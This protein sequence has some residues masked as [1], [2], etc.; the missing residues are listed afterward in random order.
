M[1]AVEQL[2]P[3]IGV[4]PACKALGVVRATWYRRQQSGDSCRKLRPTPERAL[5]PE[6][7]Q[8]VL[9]TLHSPRFAD[10]SPAEVYATL[11]D[12]GTY[13]CSVS[14]PESAYRPCR[15]RFVDDFEVRCL[16]AG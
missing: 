1:E 2:L 10:Q 6:E 3:S 15:P 9:D 11:L 12:E 14:T 5:T 7:R 4:A 16:P 8:A 13:L